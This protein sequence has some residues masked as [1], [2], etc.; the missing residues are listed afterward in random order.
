M[1][2]VVATDVCI[3]EYEGKYYF[4]NAFGTI[5][6]R[7]FASFGKISLVCRIQQINHLN[8]N[9]ICVT[10]LIDDSLFLNTFKDI[11]KKDT[12][13]RLTK[14]LSNTSLCIVRQPSVIGCVVFEL[15]HKSGNF[16][17]AENMCDAFES[18]WTHSL[19]GKIVAPWMYFWTKRIFHNTDYALYVTNFFLQKR[20]PCVCPSIS[21]SNVD[22]VNLDSSIISRRL[23]KIKSMNPRQIKVMTIANV[24]NRS[25][26][27]VY[28]IRAIP[29]LEKLGFNIRYFLVGG[30]DQQYLKDVAEKLG[31]SNNVEFLGKLSHNE[32]MLALD[33]IDIYV[34]PS[35]QEGLPRAV[36]EA[37]SRG[38]P[39]IG[40]NTAGIPELI[41]RTCIFKKHSSRDIVRV[42]NEIVSSDQL[43]ILAEKNFK[44][45]EN[46][47]SESLDKK[48]Q[49][50]FS[51]IYEE[52]N[53]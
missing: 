18:Y 46:Y 19:F 8:S 38:C 9:L 5:L 15:A 12:L 2:V 33:E 41:D 40:A 28:F 31:V 14:L 43:F 53:K 30:G 35:L 1:S 37:M 48:R 45:A 20:Y 10:N 16:I 21:A 29:L 50:F 27:Q 39:C 42:F 22:I 11:L 36:I 26:G 17:L 25:K 51:M 52:I 13:V 4:Q 34:H 44:N 47:L 49:R 6:S 7:Y 23:S 32:V 24:D 3:L